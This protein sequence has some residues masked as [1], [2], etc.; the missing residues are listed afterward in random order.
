MPNIVEEMLVSYNKVVTNNAEHHVVE[1][2]N[3]LNSAAKA[4]DDAAADRARSADKFWALVAQVAA[5]MERKDSVG[6]Y[7]GEALDA[8]IKL[9]EL[10][11]EMS[12]K[13]SAAQTAMQN[14]QV[15]LQQTSQVFAADIHKTETVSMDKQN[16]ERL[17]FDLQENEKKLQ[18]DISE[19]AKNQAAVMESARREAERAQQAE[20]ERLARYNFEK[21]RLE[22]YERQIETEKAKARA[23]GITHEDWLVLKAGGVII[24]REGEPNRVM[25]LGQYEWEIKAFDREIQAWEKKRQAE[26]RERGPSHIV[27]EQL[28]NGCVQLHELGKKERILTKKEWEREK[29]AWRNRNQTRETSR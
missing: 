24:E 11:A 17:L 29:K 3:A 13:V 14:Q 15:P 1:E 4:L 22:I 12:A 8:R 20:E 5:E 19:Q 28:K 7:T 6:N 21:E 10:L 2:A 9:R 26:A 27:V 16:A 18:Y 23:L 25:T